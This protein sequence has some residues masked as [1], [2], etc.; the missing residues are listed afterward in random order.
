M[1]Y[2]QLV[3]QNGLY[4]KN[5]PAEDQTYDICLAAVTQNGY[6]LQFVCEA[7]NQDPNICSVAVSNKGMSLYFVADQTYDLC[8]QAV[9]QDG[10]ALQVI[11]DHDQENIMNIYLAAVQQNGLVLRYCRQDKVT[12]SLSLAAVQQNGLALLCVENQTEQICLAAVNQ[13]GY[14]LNDSDIRNYAV[15][16][17]A[18]QHTPLALRFVKKALVSEDYA[19]L[20]MT[21]VSAD[22]IALGF[23]LPDDQT[24][25]LCL[26]A[27]TQNGYSLDHVCD[28]LKEDSTIVNAARAQRIGSLCNIHK[29]Y[30]QYNGEECAGCCNSCVN[31]HKCLKYHEDANM[32]HI[33]CDCHDDESYNS[34]TGSCYYCSLYV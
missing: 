13:N 24:S 34:V 31:Y 32:E 6:A 14:A 10:N 33:H 15:C 9:Q 22:G 27:V 23:V 2:L 5:I 11:R 3:Q 18:I 25:E 1:N 19:E 28:D 17:A 21:A 12:E 29:N 4:L 20:C 7:Y 30:C 8:M 26:T 16:L